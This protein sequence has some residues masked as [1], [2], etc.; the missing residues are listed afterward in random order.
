[1]KRVLD[2]TAALSVLVI[3]SPW[4][5][6]IALAIWI[7][8]LHGPF[9]IGRRV[10]RN[11]REFGMIKFRTMRPNAWKSGVNSTSDDD[12]RITR[13]GKGLRRFKIDEMPQ[14]INVLKGEM[15]LVGPRPQVPLDAAMYTA[16]ERSMLKVRPGIT[17]LASIVFA[18]EGSILA[19]SRDP[20]LDYNRLIRPW[21]SRLALVYVE[22]RSL[23]LD[24]RIV[25][26]T[27]LGLFSRRRALDRVAAQVAR[28]GA[29]E[30]LA[31][32]CARRAPLVAYPPP[33][34]DR[35]VEK[36]PSKAMT[37]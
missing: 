27:A 14:L 1:M 13:I 24:L 34:A 3:F 35:I 22:R 18:D 8:D 36:Y 21:K 2:G 16:A 7:A 9:Y 12:R 6:L 29:G 33:G 30:R 15:S 4:L 23:R 32:I 25:A 10:G 31:Q 11:G 28:M 19:G 5:I 17:D 37:A 26:W 20:D